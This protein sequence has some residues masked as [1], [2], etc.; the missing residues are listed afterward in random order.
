MA[1]LLVSYYVTRNRGTPYGQ[2]IW[3]D[4]QVENYRTTTRVKGQ[5]GD[6]HTEAVKPDW[7]SIVTLNPAQVEAVREAVSDANLANMPGRIESNPDADEAIE[8]AEWQV[9]TPKGVKRV[10]LPNWNP[11]DA[12]QRPLLALIQ[13]MGE[14]VLKA[15]S[16]SGD[17]P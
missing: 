12:P 9:M 17:T 1:Q 10:M 11:A 8:Q 16:G 3:D 14:I 6:Y 2:R 7:Y 4:G 13:C 15:Q 5:D